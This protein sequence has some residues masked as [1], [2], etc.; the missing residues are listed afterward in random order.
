[1]KKLILKWSGLILPSGVMAIVGRVLAP[2]LPPFANDRGYLPQW[3]NW[4]QTPFN[5]LDGDHRHL[6]R[7]PGT[8]IW[9]TYKRRVAW[10]LRNV[11]YG[12]DMKVCGIPVDPDS[13]VIEVIGNPDISDKN[14]VSGY[15]YWFAYRNN[16]LI[17]WQFYYIYHYE[18]FGL[19]KCVRVGMGWKLWSDEKL[20]EEPAQ[21]FAY[22]HPF[23]TAFN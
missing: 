8:D 21:Y 20:R 2:F 10:L 19:K 17:A 18:A 23:K 16:K 7:W 3:L 14:G 6:E 1:M 13:D 4:F 12:F 15:C 22:A 9:S 5:S 11:C